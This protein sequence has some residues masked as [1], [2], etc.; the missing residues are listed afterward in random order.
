[1][2][3]EQA[4]L[5]GDNSPVLSVAVSADGTRIVTGSAD[6]IARVWDAKA[7]AELGVL[8]GHTGSVLSVTMSPD[9]ARIL[10]RRFGRD[11]TSVGRH[12]LG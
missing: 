2:L 9:G 10:N 5:N 7:L 11:G 3:R 12:H 6:H 4:V 1:M 8:K